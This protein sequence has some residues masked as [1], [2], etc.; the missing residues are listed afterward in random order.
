MGCLGA[1]QQLQL[2]DSCAST[3]LL[4]QQFIQSE[5]IQ[6]FIS[7]TFI[8]EFLSF[9]TTTTRTPILIHHGYKEISLF[10]SSVSDA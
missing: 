7:L 5:Q 9:C 10:Y 4:M 8:I 2:A 1:S 3:L 6:S